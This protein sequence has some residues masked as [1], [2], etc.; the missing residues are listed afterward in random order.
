LAFD[1]DLD[2]Q[3]DENPNL[4]IPFMADDDDCESDFALMMKKCRK[5]R[6]V[7]PKIK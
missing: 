6:V 1:D 7:K 2:A 3:L 4:I 5:P